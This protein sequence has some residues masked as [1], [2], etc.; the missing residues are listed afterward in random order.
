MIPCKLEKGRQ[1]RG[2]DGKSSNGRGGGGGEIHTK[3]TAPSEQ[4]ASMHGFGIYFILVTHTV[5][6][7]KYK[8]KLILLSL[9]LS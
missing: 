6:K 2:N 1:W 4:T 5:K 8:L 7:Y 9:R 3:S